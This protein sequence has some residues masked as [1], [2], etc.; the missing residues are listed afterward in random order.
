[1]S[2]IFNRSRTR[3]P[4]RAA[5][6]DGERIYAIG[7][8]DGCI[9]LLDRTLEDKEGVWR[10]GFAAT[11]PMLRVECAPA[12]GQIERIAIDGGRAC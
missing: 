6:A 5:V 10:H 11:E 7:D 3:E 8:V 1:M 9:N 12:D 2:P 4:S